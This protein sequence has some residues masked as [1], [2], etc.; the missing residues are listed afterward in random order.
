MG[1]L[2][3]K[4]GEDQSTN[5]VT[6]LILVHRR[7][8][9]TEHVYVILYS[10]Q[11]IALHWTDNERPR[12]YS[13]SK[14][15]PA[16]ATERHRWCEITRW[17][18]TPDNLLCVCVR[19]HCKLLSRMHARRSLSTV[20]GTHSGQSTPPLLSSSHSPPF[21]PRNGVRSHSRCGTE[22]WTE[23]ELA[24][25]LTVTFLIRLQGPNDSLH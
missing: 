6:I 25:H 23:L 12:V 13:C 7:R 9:D 22:S 21:S 18:L 24:F 19:W 14:D 20:G 11:C 1:K 2:C 3:S 4:F 8:T 17:Y 5:N 16:W 15:K 10:V